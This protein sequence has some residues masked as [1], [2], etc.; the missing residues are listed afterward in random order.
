VL[1][2][3]VKFDEKRPYQSGDLDMYQMDVLLTLLRDILMKIR[4][5]NSIDSLLA[6][7]SLAKWLMS[8]NLPV[9]SIGNL[10]ARLTACAQEFE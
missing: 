4:D 1:A 8:D 2:E 7:G 6:S 10:D 3:W 9:E 5:G